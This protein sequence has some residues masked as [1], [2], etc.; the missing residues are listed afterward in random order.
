MK[1]G[2]LHSFSTGWLLFFEL[3]ALLCGKT[4]FLGF[5]W[6]CSGADCMFPG[7]GI[8]LVGDWLFG[9]DFVEGLVGNRWICLSWWPLV[10][11]ENRP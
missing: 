9:L 1:R 11:V 5:V 3:R 7:D 4:W 8:S 10:L 2:E 6:Y